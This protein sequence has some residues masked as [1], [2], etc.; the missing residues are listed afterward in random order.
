MTIFVVTSVS[1]LQP[2]G[3]S[4]KRWL[5]P[6]LRILA[7]RAANCIS[8]SQYSSGLVKAIRGQGSSQ[9]AR[10]LYDYWIL[11]CGVRI[12]GWNPL[13]WQSRKS[14]RTSWRSCHQLPFQTPGLPS[15]YILP[16]VPFIRCPSLVVEGVLL[17]AL[18]GTLIPNPS[19]AFDLQS[20]YFILEQTSDGAII[21]AARKLQRATV[22]FSASSLP[23]R[24]ETPHLQREVL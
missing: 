20:T 12:P 3:P 8:T 13:L 14:R 2:A 19:S 17:T 4:F 21:S 15:L 24:P 23:P 9:S 7:F 1:P 6:K 22:C 5:R 16:T 11:H 18:R 10:V